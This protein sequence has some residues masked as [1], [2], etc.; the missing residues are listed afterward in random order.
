MSQVGNSTKTPKGT[1]KVEA[2]KGWLRLRFT[3]QGKRR[4]FAIGLPDTKTNQG[5]AQRTATQ[6]ELDIKS[7]HFDAT[8][9][10]YKPQKQLE[11][12][13]S[14]ELTVIALFRSFVE[15]KAKEVT[16]KTMEKYQAT[17][18]YLKCHFSKKPVK[19]LD[20]RNVEEFVKHQ[21]KQGLSE[22]QIKRRLE[23]LAAAW[24]WHEESHNPW[25][26][27]AGR[28]KVPPKQQPKP[29]SKEEIRAI[30][31][32]FRQNKYYAQYADFVE[33]LLCTG[34]RTCEAIGLRWRHLS[35]DCSSIWI[36]EPWSRGQ[37]CRPKMN[38]DRSFALNAKVQHLLLSRKPANA[39][40]DDLVFPSPR[41]QGIDDHNFS[42]RI[43]KKML[44]EAG[45]PYRKFYSTR[46]TVIS[47]AL[48][49]GM[50]PVLISH[51][52]GHD[53]KTMLKHYAGIVNSRPTLPE[54]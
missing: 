13:Q 2:D 14:P 21:F 44:K 20:D 17:S 45:V 15:Y 27:W 32:A 37:Q 39:K 9:A 43:W 1:V 6:I 19:L 48:E 24:E 8:L 23:E 7:G 33:F 3:H 46:H 16:P 35:E 41:G 11:I 30:D 29:F 53:L 31:Q 50:S 22:N 54:I 26:K 47:H 5:I 51:I 25:K 28:I 4:A 34:C 12:E 40:P 18:N 10:R 36:G 38:K 52:A 42:Q 49:S